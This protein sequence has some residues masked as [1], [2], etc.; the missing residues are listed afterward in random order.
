MANKLTKLSIVASAF[1]TLTSTSAFAGENLI[2]NGSFEDYT[3]NSDHGRWKEVT[4][5]NWTGAGE[6][7]NSKIGK[8]A[9]KGEHKIELDVGRELNELSQIVSTV[10]GRKYKLSIDAYARRCR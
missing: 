1:L 6:A 2:Q 4:F 8:P 7:W 10:E 5:N 9:T 3:I